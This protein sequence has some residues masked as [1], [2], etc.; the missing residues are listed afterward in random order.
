MTALDH[1]SIVDEP[2]TTIMRTPVY[3][4][5]EDVSLLHALG[6]M[7]AMGRRHLAVV[8]AHGRCHGVLGDRA[9][10][11]AWAESPGSLS[12]QHVAQ[13]LDRRPATIDAG[14]T[15]RDVARRM[16]TDAIDAVVVIDRGGCPVGMVTGGDLIRLLART[17][18]SQPDPVSSD[19]RG[20]SAPPSTSTSTSPA[21]ATAA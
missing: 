15:V 8:D 20:Y 7:M 17:P 13:F 14:A 16:H 6:A 21:A 1:Q 18:P 10:A 12:A 3:T 4:V 11:A 2:I 5:T 9:V 19:T